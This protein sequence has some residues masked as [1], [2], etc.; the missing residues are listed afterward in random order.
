MSQY[1]WIVSSPY[2]RSL[3]MAAIINKSWGLPV[4]VEFD[5]HEWTPD[6]W[7][8]SSAE[9]IAE[10]YHDYVRHK[11]CCPPGEQ[12]LWETKDSL[13]QRTS[14]VLKKYVGAFNLIVVY[15]GMVIAS[16]LPYYSCDRQAFRNVSCCIMEVRLHREEGGVTGVIRQQT[17]K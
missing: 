2:T 7:Q 15:H 9:E 3:Q 12:K 11:G 5:L 4:K 8:A 14:S 13:M 17:E 10:L 1:E 6:Q 16:P